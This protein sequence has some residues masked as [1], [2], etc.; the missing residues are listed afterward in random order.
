M[1]GARV[2]KIDVVEGVSTYSPSHADI[3]SQKAYVWSDGI[4][5]FWHAY[6][7]EWFTEKNVAV[8]EECGA[9][10]AAAKGSVV[11]GNVPD[12]RQLRPH[13]RLLLFNKLG[14]VKQ[15]GCLEQPSIIALTETW[16]TPDVPD[17]E[18]SVD[19]H[20]GFRA[21]SK[22]GRAGGVALYLHAALQIPIVLSDSTPAPFCDALWVRIPLRGIPSS[23][24]STV[25]PLVLLKMTDSS[26]KALSNSPPTTI[27]LISCWAS[28]QVDFL[29]W[30]CL[31][32]SNRALGLNMWLHLPDTTQANYHPSWTWSSPT[33]GTS[34]I[35][36]IS[37]TSVPCK[38]MERIMKRAILDHLTSSN[39][40]SPAQHGFLPN[41]SCV[42][43]VLVFM[44][45]LTQ[46][47]DEGFISDVIF[48][49]FAK[50]SDR[51]PHVPLLH[52]LESYGIQGKILRWIKAFLSDRSFRVRI[53][54]TYSSPAPVSIGVPQGSVLGPLL[55]LIYVND[56]PDVL[57]SPCLLFADDL[58]SWSSNASA[59]QMDVDAAKQW[60][61]DWHLPLND[62][63]YQEG[64][65]HL[66]ILKLVLLTAPREIAQKTFTILRTIRLTFSR[67]TR[68]DFQTLYG[69]YVRPLPEYANQVVYL[70]RKKDA[71]LI[72][73]VQRAA[74]RMVAGLKSVDYETRLATLDLF[75][76]EY[77][78]LRRGTSKLSELQFHCAN[79]E[80]LWC[81]QPHYDWLKPR[82]REHSE[83][84]PAEC[85][86]YAAGCSMHAMGASVGSDSPKIGVHD[87]FCGWKIE[88]K[89]MN[90]SPIDTFDLWPVSGSPS[91]KTAVTS[92]AEF[93][94]NGFHTSLPSHC[95][96]ASGSLP[97][98]T[99][100]GEK[101]PSRKSVD[102]HT[103]HVA[104]PAQPVQCDQFIY[105]G[106]CEMLKF[107]AV[108]NLTTAFSTM[109][110]LFLG[111]AITFDT[112]LLFS[113]KICG[114][115]PLLG[116]LTVVTRQTMGGKLLVNFPLGNIRYKHIPFISVVF[117]ALL[118]LLGITGRVSF[119][120]FATGILVAWVYLRFFQRHSNGIV[121]DL[122][123]TFTFSGFFPN[124]LEPPVAI[125]ANTTFN[126]L[127]RLKLC[128]KAP[129]ISVKQPA[130]VM[131]FTVNVSEISRASDIGHTNNPATEILTLHVPPDSAD[132]STS[133]NIPMISKGTSPPNSKEN[134]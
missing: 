1:T 6:K 126:L 111:Y 37:L 80:R 58:K 36:P 57:A 93:A 55:F 108:V 127:L 7:Y 5:N 72:E 122:A 91:R 27:S 86:L 76:L 110:F 113:E 17:A 59:L 52:K 31:K 9:A 125:L 63:K 116:G 82:R 109:C 85:M 97:P 11:L 79:T 56:L 48:S 15:S 14:D 117:A 102:W 67:I 18:I 33:K 121:G 87:N 100:L 75:P 3:F 41:R 106:W 83:P 128:R 84:G 8:R 124:H 133:A 99:W 131:S 123:D 77:R 94:G 95:L 132:L 90:R 28:N 26:Y 21:A 120:M 68:M 42:T 24:R 22:R 81:Y 12:R 101:S 70:G 10:H 66:G 112:E 103:Q 69:A 62:E 46:T 45:S 32:S 25:A 47:K 20:C 88:T 118:A 40:I 34:L 29:Q 98:F 35:R 51:V 105:R 92:A 2:F 38:V 65:G 64:F 44:D 30:R 130:S 89:P 119:M 16:L 39:L 73:R 71:T 54:S 104:K 60:S 74:T 53:G 96:T 19:V 49:D 50:A 129:V 61:L 114:F 115:I 78:R 134:P 107:C 23:E 4:G 43:N 13:A